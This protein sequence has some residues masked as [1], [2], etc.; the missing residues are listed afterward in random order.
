MKKLRW[1][2]ISCFLVGCAQAQI[3]LDTFGSPGAT[4]AVIPTS[5]W[6]GNVSQTSTTMSVSAHNDN[7]WGTTSVNINGSAMTQVTFVAQR[8]AGHD[9]STQLFIQFEDS[10]LNTKVYSVATTAFNIGSMTTVSINLTNWTS[11]FDPSQITGWNIGGGNIITNGPAFAM[12]FDTLSLT[13]VPEPST[14][15]AII[16]AACL[17]LAIVKKQ[18]RGSESTC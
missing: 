11:G 5:S 12:T 18:R 7:G 6:F 10:S 1:I 2:G 13:A 16:G 4:G 8:D 17:G 14:Y 3:V 9:S 15:A